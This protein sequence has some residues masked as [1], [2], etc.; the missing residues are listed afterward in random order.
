MKKSRAGKSGNEGEFPAKVAN[1]F[2]TTEGVVRGGV[3]YHKDGKKSDVQAARRA[4]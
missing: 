3:L 4:T 2:Y 1:E